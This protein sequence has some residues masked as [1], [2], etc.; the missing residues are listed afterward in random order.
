MAAE[1][2]GVEVGQIAKS[3]VVKAKN[4]RYALVLLAGDRRL[5]DR[6]LKQLLGAKTRMATAE[7]TEAVTGYRPGGVCPFDVGPVA[8]DPAHRDVELYIDRSLEAWPTIYPAAGTDAS[9]VPTTFAQLRQLVGA[10]EC[11]VAQG[12]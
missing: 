10:E 7:E 8:S 2:L 11:D 1:R 4:G 3:I 6:R 9:G 5:D 12:V